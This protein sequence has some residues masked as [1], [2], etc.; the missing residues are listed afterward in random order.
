MRIV[1]ATVKGGAAL[2]KTAHSTDIGLDLIAISDPIIVGEE[3][4]DG[5]ASIDY[6]EYDTGVSIAPENILVQSGL[7]THDY[8]LSAI[9]G[10]I[11]PRSSLSKYN[12]ALANGV[13]VIDPAYRDTIKVRFKYVMQ[14]VDLAT[15]LLG[16][17]FIL[18]PNI[19]KIYRRGDKIAQLVFA[20][21][22]DIVFNLVESLD[23]TDRGIGGFGS[24]G[25]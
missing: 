4:E 20:R 15:T 6:I 22:T 1:N 18:K 5:Y 21:K 9:Y 24:T 3:L 11:F 17:A 12:L 19:N 25:T 13:G 7:R 2:P 16:R 23:K 8:N 10:Q 14:P